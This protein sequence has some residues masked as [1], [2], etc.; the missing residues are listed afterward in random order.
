LS[1][2]RSGRVVKISDMAPSWGAAPRRR[3]VTLSASAA[4]ATWSTACASSI[5][6]G[7]CRWSSILDC[8]F[9]CAARRLSADTNQRLPLG[10]HVPAE[11]ERDRHYIVGPLY[12]RAR[13]RTMHRH[14]RRSNCVFAK[15]HRNP[16]LCPPHQRQY[17]VRFAGQPHEPQCH[18]QSCRRSTGLPWVH[19][20]GLVA[21][22]QLHSGIRSGSRL[23]T[24]RVLAWK[25]GPGGYGDV[26]C[27]SGRRRACDE[28]CLQ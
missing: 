25:R 26:R 15:L 22:R 28:G 24:C 2:R 5:T 1:E 9:L 4:A 18:A 17:D 8:G 20:H 14:R 7:N 27:G 6:A 3:A 13:S 16:L 10:L 19:V 12:D 11:P 21:N 23:H